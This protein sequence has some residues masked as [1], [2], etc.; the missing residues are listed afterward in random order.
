L[1]RG[2]DSQKLIVT[3]AAAP[4]RAEGEHVV[5]PAVDDPP[6][7]DVEVPDEEQA[8]RSR[9]AAPIVAASAVTREPLGR[10]GPL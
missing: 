3:G 10:M 4:D 5:A 1:A 6:D 9:A 8:D 2:I 7:V